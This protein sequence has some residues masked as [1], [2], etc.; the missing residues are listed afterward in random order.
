MARDP[1]RTISIHGEKYTYDE[2]EDKWMSGKKQAT[3]ST[4]A[5]LDMILKQL[6]PEGD[7][8]VESFVGTAN[9][10]SAETEEE[11]ETPEQKQ[12]K[13]DAHERKEEAQEDMEGEPP[14]VETDATALKPA[15]TEG[16]VAPV[17]EEIAQRDRPFVENENPILDRN[18]EPV[19]NKPILVADQTPLES[20][21]PELIRVPETR[22]KPAEP[23]IPAEPI[24]PATTE[25]LVPA[26][27]AAAEPAGFVYGEPIKIG[28]D[29][30]KLGDPRYEKIMGPPPAQQA[31]PAPVAEPVKPAPTEG[32]A[33]LPK[34]ELPEGEQTIKE[35]PAAEQPKSRIQQIKQDAGVKMSEQIAEKIPAITLATDKAADKVSTGGEVLRD[36]ATNIFEMFKDVQNR[37]KQAEAQPIE[38][39]ESLEKLTDLTPDEIKRLEERGIA[40]ASEKDF[41]YRKEGKPLSKEDLISELNADADERNSQPPPPEPFYK[42]KAAE[43]GKQFNKSFKKQ[44]GEKLPILKLF[45]DKLDDKDE[46]EGAQAESLATQVAAA[47]TAAEPSAAS[48]AD[49]VGVTGN[50]VVESLKSIDSNIQQIVDILKENK[51]EVEEE[52][53]EEEQETAEKETQ[54]E[55]TEQ[56]DALKNQQVEEL[57]ARSAPDGAEKTGAYALG[58]K[59]R[60]GIDKIK[61]GFEKIKGKFGGT[62]ETAATAEA[63]AVPAAAAETAAP[64]MAEGAA[65]GMAEGAVA[66]GK[67]GL[68]KGAG[69]ALKKLGKFLPGW[70]KLLSF[71]P[72]ADGGVVEDA[73]AIK[74]FADGGVVD[75]PTA[76]SHKGGTGVMGEAGAEAIMPLKRGPDGKLGVKNADSQKPAI[77]DQTKILSD[78]QDMRKEKE[79]AGNKA[80]PAGAT[81]INNTTTNNNQSGGGGGGGYFP[82]AG[83]RNSLD[84]FY[85]A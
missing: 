66:A 16:L 38:K 65:G 20:G 63:E 15:I 2:G 39:R 1:N 10:V 3:P 26:E 19:P 74:M 24:K 78:A 67:A 70:G 68:M 43:L 37:R 35:T 31:Q 84:L 50:V 80:Q 69:K 22:I 28:K 58:E 59:T 27:P 33:P 73:H 56:A 79:K 64:A 85:Y 44:L 23:L 83:A 18:G 81:I 60:G 75:Q 7:Q 11:E 6:E 48:D 62:A 40:P 21:N 13:A 61:E 55:E 29:F 9:L 51:E 8:E 72:F 36:A 32:L 14:A 47:P 49:A 46:E 54:K 4:A 71:L 82:T 25:G 77:T 30:I 12:A 53:K 52:D 17:I 41:S 76:F 57:S 34:P 42:K 45:T 5:M